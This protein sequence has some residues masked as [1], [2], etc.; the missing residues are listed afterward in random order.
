MSLLDNLS[1]CLICA[2]EKFQMSSTGFEP[3]TSEMPVQ[4]SKQL[5]YE[6]TQT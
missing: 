5:S 4:S 3:T 6:A 1:D 2:P